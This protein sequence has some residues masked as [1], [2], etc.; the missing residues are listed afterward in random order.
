MRMIKIIKKYKRIDWKKKK[1][2][3]RFCEEVS[4]VQPT[5]YERKQLIWKIL[6]S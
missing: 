4:E 1:K 2:K 5:S 6:Q 3:V